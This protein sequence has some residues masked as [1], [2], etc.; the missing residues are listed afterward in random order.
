MAEQKYNY[1]LG[2]IKEI[3]K[4]HSG[5]EARQELEKHIRAANPKKDSAFIGLA[6]KAASKA[7][8][9]RGWIKDAHNSRLTVFAWPA[10]K[11]ALYRKLKEEGL[12]A[13]EMMARHPELAEDFKRYPGTPSYTLGNFMRVIGYNRK[14]LQAAIQ[15]KTAKAAKLREMEE[16]AQRKA[17]DAK[18]K[19]DAK[20][21]SLVWNNEASYPA[22]YDVE[23]QLGA[24]YEELKKRA[25]RWRKLQR[26]RPELFLPEIKWR[27]EVIGG[28]VRVP[29]V[30]LKTIFDWRY[31]AEQFIK[32]AMEAG[33]FLITAAQCSSY[34]HKQVYATFQQIQ[35][36][37]GYP[38]AIHPITYGR[39]METEFVRETG[40]YRLKRSFPDELKGK[41]LFENVVFDHC[42]LEINT[43]RMRPTLERFL[44]PAVLERG[45]TRSQ[46]YAG[47][48]LELETVMR[49]GHQ[50]PK[51]VMTTGAV[52]YPSYN[53]NKLGQQ[54]RVGEIAAAEH[55][56]AA[57]IVEFDSDGKSFHHRQLIV[58][59]QGEVYDIDPERE[60]ATFFTPNGVE[61]RPKAVKWVYCGDLHI[62]ITDPIVEEATFGK[63]GIVD[64]LKPDNIILG[65]TVDA[66]SVNH[67]DRIFQ[68]ARRAWKATYGFD[69][70]DLE[71]N[72]VIAKLKW[73]SKQLTTFVPDGK[74][75]MISANHPEMVTKYIESRAWAQPG[76]DKNFV[77][78]AKM[79]IA[80]AE[81]MADPKVK[82]EKIGDQVLPALG[83]DV[84][85][86]RPI[87]PIIWYVK[88]HC[89][90]VRCYE[91]H[92][93]LYS[94]KGKN[95]ILLSLHGD[96][97]L[98]GGETRSTH[99]YR[100][101]GMRV[102]L[103][104]NHSPQID[105]SAWRVG[106]S[107]RRTQHYVKF[108][109][110]TWGQAHGI[111]FENDQRM[112]LN[113]VQGRWHGKRNKVSAKKTK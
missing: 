4:R 73:I 100:K 18:L 107:T 15:A 23:R 104:H 70:L 40:E 75:H 5:P 25:D 47:P 83:P 17:A 103:G 14:K 28:V 69:S 81:S 32:D 90:E 66:W 113:F 56:F 1:D 80:M 39:Q 96:I 34:L 98:R 95:K 77:I 22:K 110:T 112:L 7:A 44:T 64:K 8:N 12:T 50:N 37:T 105:G 49:L 2:E 45:G 55:T 74:V 11:K 19:D 102:M 87:D 61:H 38:L 51:Q 82:M 13:E 106:T 36:H 78:S 101:V 86:A 59:K 48:K 21:F 52:T 9:D 111:I 63:G 33:G 76:Q 68:G 42:Q 62:G 72:Y 89:P 88:Q 27:Q 43:M 71:M 99:E 53:V 31:P 35:Q 41:I 79:A 67:Y 3:F 20:K 85:D 29:E 58:T 60:G 84:L 54:D 108:P 91:R 65:D 93:E 26:E 6:I 10:E 97:G 30:L 46:I 16:E 57:I 24:N 94:S 109:G 92:E